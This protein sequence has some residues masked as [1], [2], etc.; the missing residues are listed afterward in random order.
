MMGEG[1]GLPEVAMTFL[2]VREPVEH[3]QHMP[4]AVQT[5]RSSK[6]RTQETDDTGNSRKMRTV[7]AIDTERDPFTLTEL[8][9]WDLENDV[10]GLTSRSRCQFL[11]DISDGMSYPPCC[12]LVLILLVLTL[13]RFL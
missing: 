4:C 10:G 1:A 3:L 9:E 7:A 13:I 5:S 12:F 11:A 6:N 2:L 8:A